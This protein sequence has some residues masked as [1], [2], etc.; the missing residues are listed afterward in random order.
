MDDE[1]EKLDINEFI[2]SKNNNVMVSETF[3]Y[4]NPQPFVAGKC[5]K[6]VTFQAK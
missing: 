3:T 6:P 4:F 5:F 1:N 2:Q